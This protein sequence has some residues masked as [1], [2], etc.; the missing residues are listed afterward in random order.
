MKPM[1]P[2][3]RNRRQMPTT[4]PSKAAHGMLCSG[5]GAYNSVHPPCS[6]SSLVCRP[7]S[8]VG[9]LYPPSPPNLA[10]ITLSP[11][12]RPLTRLTVFSDLP[13]CCRLSESL[14]LPEGGPSWPP[15]VPAFL[16]S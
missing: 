2:A 16:P 9:V 5:A 15:S 10:G 7:A 1:L 6:S 12:H 8:P 3:M 14:S 4:C 11:P 13:A